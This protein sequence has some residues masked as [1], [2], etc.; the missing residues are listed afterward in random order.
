V[1]TKKNNTN[2]RKLF[3]LKLETAEVIPDDAV[4]A[5]LMRK[6][7]RQEFSRF[8]PTPLN[9]YYIA[10]LLVTGIG[11]AV[12]VLSGPVNSVNLNSTINSETLNK[13]GSDSYIELLANQP[14]RKEVERS[15][16]DTDKSKAANSV[17]HVKEKK[18]IEAPKVSV[19]GQNN[20]FLP[21]NINKSLSK[22]GL[23]P[24]GKSEK[25]KLRSGIK[26]DLFMIEPNTSEGCAPFKL[27]FHNNVVSYDS[28]RWT[29]GDGGNSNEKDP[30][31][32]FDVEGEYKVVLQIF[33]HDGQNL[34]SFATVTVH[35]KPR[36]HFEI[37]PEKAVLPD[38]EI[39]FLNYS[40][41]AVRFRWNFGD[42]STSE[43]F[44]PTHTYAKFNN[45]DISL[46]VY[47]DWGCS[48][49][50]IVSNAF[51]GSEY[52]IDFPNAFFPN[53]QGPTGGYF[54]T[55][56][57]ESAQ[58]FHPSYSG[59]AEYQLKIFSKLGIPIFESVDINLGWDG[60]NKGQLCEPGVY[61][62]KV[63]GKYRNGEPF[64]KIGDVTLLKN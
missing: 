51:S 25:R 54:S 16:A 55:K 44:E 27:Q 23:Y 38:D 62:W 18:A 12:L 28:C 4:K 29:F 43:F 58:I 8:N 35:P 37:I 36:A 21:V 39:H 52:F 3:R 42:G 45:Y 63:R 32:L 14:V 50:L 56:S 30:E 7:A 15:I 24:G 34:S 22:N 53:E 5:A 13:P 9:I 47:S 2:L 49:S 33:N 60:Y 59:V 19:T 40:V 31:W 61:I 41:N 64:I 46:V 57:D 48:D 17:S 11:I 6:V 20:T 26:P 1:K 10:G